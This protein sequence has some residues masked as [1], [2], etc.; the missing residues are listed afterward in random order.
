MARRSAS[1]RADGLFAGEV[2]HGGG[3][4]LT[5]ALAGGDHFSRGP[6]NT[7]NKV[8]F[9]GDGR[10]TQGAGIAGR[11]FGV[12]TDALKMWMSPI[13]SLR[14]RA[15]EVS[16]NFLSKIAQYNQCVNAHQFGLKTPPRYMSA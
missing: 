1:A 8:A 9:V 14:A 13:G 4:Q 12:I 11:G 2:A 16:A 15:E 7:A 5:V 10:P 3:D 6:F